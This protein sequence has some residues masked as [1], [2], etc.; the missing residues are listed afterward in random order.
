MAK[1]R[2]TTT[3]RLIK[4]SLDSV[5]VSS[6]GQNWVSFACGNPLIH[7]RICGGRA[8]R[9]LVLLSYLSDALQSSRR[10]SLMM[11]SSLFVALGMMYSSVTCRAKC[12]QVLFGVVARV[13][14]KLLVMD[15]QV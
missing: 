10:F 4:L 6:N 12:D 11:P 9:L 1:L 15:L 3:K 8:R 13:T 14:P 7:R 2:R 5:T